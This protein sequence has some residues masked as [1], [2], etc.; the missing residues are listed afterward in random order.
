MK[1]CVNG[2]RQLINNW[3]NNQ[4]A[5]YMETISNTQPTITK[6]VTVDIAHVNIFWRK[7]ASEHGQNTKHV[8]TR[9]KV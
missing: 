5:P 8:Q 2:P 7:N 9:A 1:A 3:S 6:R 4:I